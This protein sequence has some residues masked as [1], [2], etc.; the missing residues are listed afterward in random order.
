[1]NKYE[2]KTDKA[3]APVGPYSQAIIAGDF[4]F[5]SGQIALDPATGELVTGDI[6]QETVR[7][8]ENLKAVLGEAGCTME[9]VV[10][11]TIYLR[12]MNDFATVNAVY[13]TYFGE[14]AP[15][16]G[17]VEVARLPKDVNV[18]VECIALR[19]K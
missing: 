3:P 8:M 19:S 13:A 2:V 17:T 16:R 10:K 12:N 6:K 14:I 9:H 4:V 7:V 18:E 15:A 5:C 11:T 1:M